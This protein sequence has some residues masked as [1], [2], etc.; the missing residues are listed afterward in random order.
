MSFENTTITALSASSA[1]TGVVGSRIYFGTAPQDV[2]SP[3]IVCRRVST[4]PTLSTDNG[5]PGSYRLD[6]IR[7][8]VGCYG[9]TLKICNDLIKDVR[10]V[11]EVNR[12]TIYIMQDVTHDYSDLPDLYQ[13]IAEFSSWYPEQVPA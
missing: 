4:D 3:F 5:A 6:N 10:K 7:L 13:V 8:E 11:L 12:P 9:R 2:T 1:I